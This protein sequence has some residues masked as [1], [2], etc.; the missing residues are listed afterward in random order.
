[1]ETTEGRVPVT[2]A[3]VVL[4]VW[5][6]EDEIRIVPLEDAIGIVAPEGELVM[7]PPEDE[8]GIAPPKLDSG[9]G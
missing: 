5:I 7:A 8:P 2:A 9:E 1:M 4:L 6:P 3:Q